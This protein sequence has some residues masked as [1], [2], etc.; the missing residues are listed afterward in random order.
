MADPKL[1][2][3]YSWSSPD[4]EEWVLQ[5]STELRENGVDVILDKWD[6]RE[7]NDANAFM[8]K[9]VTDAEIKKVILIC[10]QAYAE[11]ANNRSGGVG[12]EA[13]IISGEIYAAQDQAKFVAVVKERD[14]EGNAYLPAYYHSRIYIDLSDP[15]TYSE[16]FEQLLRWIYDKPVYKKPE[17]GRAPAFLAGESEAAVLATTSRFKRAVDAAKNGRAHASAA[18]EEYFAVFAVELEKMRLDAGAEPFDAAVVQSVE[19]FLPFRNEVIEMFQTLALYLDNPESWRLLHRFFERLIPYLDGENHGAGPDNFRF[20]IHELFLYALAI[21]IKHERFDAAAYL[22]QNEYFVPG[23]TDYG[24]DSMVP[25]EVFR[26]HM[27]SLVERNKR[28]ELRRLSVRA[29]ML[30][31]RC[32]GID[33]TFLQVMQADFI[34]FMRDYLDRPED[35]WHWWPETLLFSGRH[36]SAF[37][38]FARSRSASYFERAKVL[39]GIGSKDDLVPLLQTF[40]EDKRSIPSWEFD[41][42]SPVQLLGFD[43]LATKL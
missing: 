9:M 5:L 20:V 24:R 41:S 34:L 16:N 42:F 28:L 33:V 25:F 23:R 27:P 10:D 6:L 8:E 21:M 11:K 35:H 32:S 7:G 22:M 2:V 13:Q 37:E 1:F 19:A 40:K 18:V 26:S 31:E 29:D 38:V 43:Q 14:A 30:K 4:H 36:A 39:L 3:S 15:S 12:T 17:I